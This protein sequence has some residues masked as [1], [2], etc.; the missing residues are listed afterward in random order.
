MVQYLCTALRS[1]LRF[2]AKEKKKETENA[3][4]VQ[5]KNVERTKTQFVN[6]IIVRLFLD[7]DQVETLIAD[8]LKKSTH[9]EATNKGNTPPSHPTVVS[10][11]A[12]HQRRTPGPDIKSRD[13]QLFRR[14]GSFDVGQQGSF[15]CLVFWLERR[16]R[17][18]HRHTVFTSSLN[19]PSSPKATWVGEKERR[20]LGHRYLAPFFTNQQAQ[21]GERKSCEQEIGE[22]I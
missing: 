21:G 12:R 17:E 5:V 1:L 22:D 8:W 15:S 20:N 10:D 7:R 13:R 2:R 3:S 14:T 11:G 4:G 16:D 19:G 9:S 6:S 18:S